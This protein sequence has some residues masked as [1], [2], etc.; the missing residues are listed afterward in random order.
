MFEN[1]TGRVA[2]ETVC[3]PYAKLLGMEF[4]EET[5]GQ[6][7]PEKYMD[8]G[9]LRIADVPIEDIRNTG[10]S[11]VLCSDLGR[12]QKTAAQTKGNRRGELK[13]NS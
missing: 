10:E 13:G 2:A 9:I 8:G 3:P 7:S 11:N 4:P 1:L 5:F 6:Q 12:R